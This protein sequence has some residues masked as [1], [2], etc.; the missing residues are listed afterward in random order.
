MPKIQTIMLDFFYSFNLNYSLN[1][2]NQTRSDR[3]Y[4]FFKLLFFYHF[5]LIWI[6]RR[7]RQ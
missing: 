5:L 4:Q 2:I 6:I 1:R 3:W 7:V